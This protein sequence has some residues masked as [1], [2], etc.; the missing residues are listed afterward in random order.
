MIVDL[1]AYH[2]VGMYSLTQDEVRRSSA[3]KWA[4]V[5]RGR[6]GQGRG[7][8]LPGR[9]SFEGRDVASDASAVIYSAEPHDPICRRRCRATPIPIL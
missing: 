3:S 9:G 1:T 4:L 7:E 8:G 6:A 5:V 2:V